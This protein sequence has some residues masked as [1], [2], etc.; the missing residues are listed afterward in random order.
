[1]T[2]RGTIGFVGR[3]MTMPNCKCSGRPQAAADKGVRNFPGTATLRRRGVAHGGDDRQARDRPEA[4]DFHQTPCRLR[5][6]RLGPRTLVV[7]PSIGVSSIKELIAAA[8]ARPGA[9]TFASG[10]DTSPSRMCI[11]LIKQEAGI[12][13]V[14][15]PYKSAAPAMQAVLAAE[16]PRRASLNSHRSRYRGCQT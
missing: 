5:E 2:T 9:L 3:E 7:N 16:S 1:M 8:K 4:T 14:Q 6:P 10:G 13:L 15:V 12:D 11:E